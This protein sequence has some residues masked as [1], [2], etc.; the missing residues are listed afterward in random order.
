MLGD[1]RYLVVGEFY[2]RRGLH[3]EARERARDQARFY[4]ALLEGE[5][6][7]QLVAS[8]PRAPCLGPLCWDESDAEILAVSF[9]H[10]PVYVY[11]RRQEYRSPFP[12]R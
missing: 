11:E 10:M 2:L 12:G 4:R 8:F 1:A 5:T 6:G 9:D 7:Y 3:P